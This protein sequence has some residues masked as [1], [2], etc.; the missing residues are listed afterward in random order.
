MNDLH[1][2]IGNLSPEKRALLERDLC[3]RTP[4]A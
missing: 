4:V 3:N 2:R 1:E